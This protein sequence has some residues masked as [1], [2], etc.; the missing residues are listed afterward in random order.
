MKLA[1]IIP[2]AGS[3]RR[4]AGGRD[5]LDMA[6]SKLD[7]DIGGKPVLQRAIELFTN[8]EQ[9]SCIIVAGPADEKAMEQ[10]RSRHLDRLSFLGAK[11]VAGGREHRWQSV[12]AALEHVPEECTHVAVH[13]AARPCTPIEMIERVL[14]MASRY[15]AVIPAIEVSDTLKRV[16]E[17]DRPSDDVDP[18]AAILGDDT[19]GP[20]KKK[21]RVVD[22][23]VD[24]SGL[25]MVQ[26]PQVFETGLLKAAYSGIDLPEVEATDDAG[27]VEHFWRTVPPRERA[28]VGS[29]GR[30]AVVVVQGDVRNIKITRTEDVRVVRSVMGVG[31]P[32]ERPAH[33]R[34]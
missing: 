11:L 1:V 4:F 24:R 31:G 28:G 13:D 5:V 6:R 32:A 22:G 21:L 7:E 25:V 9:T 34:F 17:T 27:V 16:R 26:T 8:L 10:F 20:Q 2:A 18:L 29:S 30:D 23:G 33:K 19:P 14:E 3:S 12:K 15:P